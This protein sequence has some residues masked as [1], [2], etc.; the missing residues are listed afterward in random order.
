MNR[1]SCRYYKQAVY[2]NRHKAVNFKETYTPKVSN[3]TFCM[4]GFNNL[5]KLYVNN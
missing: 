5:L 3:S 2:Q 4:G 1:I